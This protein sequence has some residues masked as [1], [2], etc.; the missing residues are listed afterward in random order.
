MHIAI[1]LQACLG[2]NPLAL[3]SLCLLLSALDSVFLAVALMGR[4]LFY[5]SGWLW[6]M[7]HSWPRS[8]LYLK[9]KA[10]S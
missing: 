8:L 5:A 10:Q 1:M 2:F 4:V 6:R 7:W 9:G 3:A